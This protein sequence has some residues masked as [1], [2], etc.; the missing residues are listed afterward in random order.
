LFADPEFLS[1]MS[2]ERIV[3]HELAGYLRCEVVVEPAFDIDRGQFFVLRLRICRKSGAFERQFGL[4]HIACEL[5]ETYSPA[6][7]A[8]A[9]ATRSATPAI[10]T[11]PREAAADATPRSRLAVEITPSSSPSTAARSHPLRCA[12]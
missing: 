2:P 12:R 9:P 3:R 8:M 6:A 7:I 4:F 1:G 11:C 10:S 5:T